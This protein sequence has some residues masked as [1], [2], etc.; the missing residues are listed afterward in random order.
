MIIRWLQRRVVFDA[1]F[2]TEWCEKSLPAD[3]QAL[4]C[5][6]NNLNR[7]SKNLVLNKLNRHT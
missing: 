3:R 6:K 5:P 1:E 2:V 7:I 4:K